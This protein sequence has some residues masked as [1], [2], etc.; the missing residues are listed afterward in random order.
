MAESR[1]P[2]STRKTNLL[3]DEPVSADDHTNVAISSVYDVMQVA[4]Q[5]KL[6]PY[7]Q[8]NVLV[9]KQSN[10]LL[11]IE[12]IDH[13]RHNT[14]AVRGVI[15]MSAGHSYYI[16]VSDTSDFKVPLPRRMI[17]ALTTAPPH[18]THVLNCKVPPI[19]IPKIENNASHS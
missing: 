6:K 13:R 1:T 5:I 7:T 15:K 19:R 12:S 18:A 17:I 11:S 2:N 10:G 8:N 3:T 9:N 16:L 14:S 4:K